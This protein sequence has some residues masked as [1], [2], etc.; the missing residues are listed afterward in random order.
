MR[1]VLVFFSRF[2]HRPATL[3]AISWRLA[4]DNFLSFTVLYLFNLCSGDRHPFS[5]NL[6]LKLIAGSF[7]QIRSQ[8][9]YKLANLKCT[10]LPESLTVARIGFCYL[11]HIHT[12]LWFWAC[13]EN[14]RGCRMLSCQEI[15]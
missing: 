10:G 8:W 5:T 2:F 15:G 7:C 11:F 1:A 4:G 12:E 9:S 3:R 14:G 13:P 6:Y